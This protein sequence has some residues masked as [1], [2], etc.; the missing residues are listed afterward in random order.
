MRYVSRYSLLESRR[1]FSRS[2]PETGSPSQ[3]GHS[4]C[5]MRSS[6]HTRYLGYLIPETYHWLPATCYRT[7]TTAGLSP[8]SFSPSPFFGRLPGSLHSSVSAFLGLVVTST[9]THSQFQVYEAGGA[10]K[11]FVRLLTLLP[12]AGWHPPSSLSV[13]P[14]LPLS[15]ARPLVPGVWRSGS[16]GTTFSPLGLWL[17][18]MT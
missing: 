13:S 17:F 11:R 3:S 6:I 2:L 14:S 4:S 7:Y 16:S 8:L 9:L 5:Y 1:P 18:Q 10:P 12:P 15:L